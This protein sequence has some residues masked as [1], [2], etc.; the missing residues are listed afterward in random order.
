MTVPVASH[1][2]ARNAGPVDVTPIAWK[3][4]D[5]IF[6]LSVTQLSMSGDAGE[7]GGDAVLRVR[8]WALGGARA[9]GTTDSL[10]SELKDGA[11]RSVPACRGAT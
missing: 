10:A 8:P 4:R 1:I 9:R 2:C 6:R 11:V 5:A 3:R 7:Q